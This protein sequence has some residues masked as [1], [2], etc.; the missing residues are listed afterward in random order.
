VLQAYR[1][2]DRRVSCD[3]LDSASY[4]ARDI[5]E[6]LRKPSIR[7][8][9][10][11]SSVPVARMSEVDQLMASSR[12]QPIGTYLQPIKLA[13]ALQRIAKKTY[14]RAPKFPAPALDKAL[15]ECK[16]DK[17][18]NTAE[19]TNSGHCVMID[20]PDWLADQILKAV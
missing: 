5:D 3:R 17:T 2:K 7:E 13:G 12:G 10:K 15:A 19:N 11:P 9:P 1:R 16:A 20:A 6:D 18:W 14:I 4:A 8:K